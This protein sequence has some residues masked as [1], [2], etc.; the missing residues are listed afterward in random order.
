[1]CVTTISSARSLNGGF[2][3][4][5]VIFMVVIVAALMAAM[6]KLQTSQSADVDMLLLK[7]RTDL[8]VQSGAEWA[9][10]RI[11][12]SKACPTSPPSMPGITLSVLRCDV[13]TFNES[14]T[15][16]DRFDVTLEAVTTGVDRN[17]ENYASSRLDMTFMVVR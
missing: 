6:M 16:N 15:L 4:P 14:G 7:A 2:A 1:M 3:L 17:N 12:V 9:S 11:S 13:S 8:A 10:Y 5:T